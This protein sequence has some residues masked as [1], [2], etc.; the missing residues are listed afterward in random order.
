MKLRRVLP[1]IGIV[2]LAAALVV[3]GV[4]LASPA[5]ATRSFSDS[6]VDPGDSIVVAMTAA[7]YGAFGQVV[8]TL[9]S[10]F[11]YVSSS[12][13]SGQVTE[14]AGN[15]VKFTLLGDASFTY[16]VTA[17]SVEGVYTF[18]GI[19]KDADMAEFAVTG[20][21]TVT[22]GAGGVVASATRTLPAAAVAPGANFTVAIAAA[23]YGTFGQVVETLPA[24]FSYVSS[25]L[26]AD[27]IEEAAGNKVEFTLLGDASFTY[28]VT[29]STVE[30]DYYFSGIIKDVDMNEFAVGGDIAVT[31]EEGAA[32]GEYGT[33]ADWINAIFV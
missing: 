18:S 24:G 28:T 9:P 1:A 31:V 27:Q 7:G 29:A 33:F 2:M 3:P 10:G 14:E 13:P 12:L 4:V 16:T 8:E 30:G 25:S 23:D 6:T 17:S 26:P 32:P 20:D 11:T 21:T 19:I 15:K 5:T 22:V